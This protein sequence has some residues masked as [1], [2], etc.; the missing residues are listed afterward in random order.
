MITQ[1]FVGG[2]DGE[3]LSVW[4]PVP[5]AKP[6]HPSPH[7]GRTCANPSLLSLRSVCLCP[8]PYPCPFT[9]SV[10]VICL[11]DSIRRMNLS[12]GTHFTSLRLVCG[13]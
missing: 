3:D 1:R 13:C 4:F 11:P 10:S 9:R 8:V 2:S 5:F 7:R 12:I 6:L